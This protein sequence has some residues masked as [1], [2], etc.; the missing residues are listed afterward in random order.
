MTNVCLITCSDL[1][2]LM[3]IRYM[4]RLEIM[5]KNDCL[6]L[7][8]RL[9]HYLFGMLHYK[10]SSST[11]WNVKFVRKDHES[12][13]LASWSDIITKKR[14]TLEKSFFTGRNCKFIGIFDSA[15]VTYSTLRH[16]WFTIDRAANF[17]RDSQPRTQRAKSYQRVP[18]SRMQIPWI[19]QYQATWGGGKGREGTSTYIFLR[20]FKTKRLK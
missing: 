9:L 12:G 3:C 10:S 15:V 14:P 8:N 17:S 13:P 2:V 16:R 11:K 5:R 19:A 4:N 1:C 18:S 7:I 6:W 20:D